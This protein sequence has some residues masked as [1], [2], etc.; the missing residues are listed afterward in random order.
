MNLGEGE[1]HSEAQMCRSSLQVALHN[2][3]QDTE[4]SI[5]LNSESQGDETLLNSKQQQLQTPD[6]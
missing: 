4:S 2:R 3:S 1:E 5:L 6:A